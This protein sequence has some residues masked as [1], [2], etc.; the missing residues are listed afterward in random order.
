LMATDRCNIAETAAAIRNTMMI[1][2]LKRMINLAIA[3]IRPPQQMI[4][5]HFELHYNIHG[6]GLLP[7]VSPELFFMQQK[8][9]GMLGSTIISQTEDAYERSQNRPARE[10]YK[11]DA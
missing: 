7:S 6:V 2:F 11:N 1:V 4:V 5:K 8:F 9:A 10:I 3:S